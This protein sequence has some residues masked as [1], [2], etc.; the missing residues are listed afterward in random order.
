MNIPI[1]SQNIAL[2]GYGLFWVA[3]SIS[4]TVMGLVNRNLKDK[5]SE[6]NEEFQMEMRRAQEITD[7][8]RMQEEYAFKRRLLDLSR[9]Y[10]SE[11][12]AIQFDYQKKNNR[13]ATFF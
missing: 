8:K 11:Q 10:R 12:S 1:G 9:Q 4:S 2:P 6:R 5:A 13:I 3:N 7:D